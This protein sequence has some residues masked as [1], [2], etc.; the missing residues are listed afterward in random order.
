MTFE[1][2]HAT[3]FFVDAFAGDHAV[4]AD[5]DDSFEAKALA[6]FSDLTAQGVW[7]GSVAGEDFDAEDQK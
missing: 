3:Q 5:K 7:G 2:V 1:A 6:H 4:V